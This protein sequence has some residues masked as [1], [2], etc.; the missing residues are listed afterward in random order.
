MR[1]VARQ[2]LLNPGK[3]IARS[4]VSLCLSVGGWKKYDSSYAFFVSNGDKV[5]KQGRR[6]GQRGVPSNLLHTIERFRQTWNVMTTR[7]SERRSRNSNR[8]GSEGDVMSERKL[9]S[10]GAR[11]VTALNQFAD[12]LGAG[13]PI[14][15]K[16]T[17]RQVRVLPKP[18]L[19]PPAR[20]RAVRGA[21]W[22]K[23]RSFRAIIGS[24]SDDNPIMGTGVTAAL[25]D[26]AAIP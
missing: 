16:Y 1:E 21:D 19:Y 18:S 7:P 2:V 8:V 25:P 12:D 11:I 22:S 13:T 23:P 3:Q 10:R 5:I 4:C 24:E 14:E 15:A 20:V 26:R 6:G 17:V 9:S